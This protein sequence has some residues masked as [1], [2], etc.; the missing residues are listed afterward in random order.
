MLIV[1]LTNQ[2][3]Y[4]LRGVVSQISQGGWTGFRRKASCKLPMPC[5]SLYINSI[6]PLERLTA[7]INKPFCD[8]LSIGTFTCS[9]D[10]T[11]SDD[12]Y[13]LS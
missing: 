3:D 10:T 6:L 5:G 7:A 2:K 12:M 1:L 8:K 13:F 11:I 4:V 9:A